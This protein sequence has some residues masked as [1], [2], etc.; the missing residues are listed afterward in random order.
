[1]NGRYYFTDHNKIRYSIVAVGTVVESKEILIKDFNK[2]K[3]R[4]PTVQFI[5]IL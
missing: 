4:Y 2:V 3:E 5:K 1:M